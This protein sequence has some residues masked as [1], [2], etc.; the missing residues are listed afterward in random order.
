MLY[1][2]DHVIRRILQYLIKRLGSKPGT[3]GGPYGSK[4]APGG[5]PLNQSTDKETQL[6]PCIFNTF[7]E[8]DRERAHGCGPPGK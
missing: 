4:R 3:P 5:T 2:N 7:R 8:R 6:A 1:Q